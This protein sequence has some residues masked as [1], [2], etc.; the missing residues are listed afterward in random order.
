MTVNEW[1]NISE[2]PISEGVGGGSQMR[3]EMR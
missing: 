2:K 3:H 1:Q